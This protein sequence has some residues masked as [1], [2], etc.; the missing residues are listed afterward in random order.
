ML[1]KTNIIR[2]Y[3]EDI[4]E[5]PAPRSVLS[6]GQSEV[7]TQQVT[8]SAGISHDR[9]TGQAAWSGSALVAG[10]LRCLHLPALHSVQIWLVRPHM[11][12]PGGL[13]E[14]ILS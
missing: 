8:L 7:S 13:C 1:Q 2:D 12:R 3:L 10:L 9:C 6:H 11:M 4:L 5:E 14:S